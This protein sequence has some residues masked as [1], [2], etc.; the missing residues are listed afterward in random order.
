MA[1]RWKLVPTKRHKQCPNTMCGVYIGNGCRKCPKCGEIQPQTTKRKRSSSPVKPRKKKQEV[2]DGP[3]TKIYHSGNKVKVY[4]DKYKRWTWGVVTSR[5]DSTFA[6]TGYRYRVRLLGITGTPYLGQHGPTKWHLNR[7]ETS[8]LKPRMSSNSLAEP[9]QVKRKDIV[10]ADI[11]DLIQDNHDGLL[12]SY[13]QYPNCD[14]A[15]CMLKFHNDNDT[16]KFMYA[17]PPKIKTIAK[18]F[19]HLKVGSI[20]VTNAVNNWGTICEVKELKLCKNPDYSYVVLENADPDG[21]NSRYRMTVKHKYYTC[22]WF[23]QDGQPRRYYNDDNAFIEQSVNEVKEMANGVAIGTPVTKTFKHDMNN[24]TYNIV[25]KCKTWK[26]PDGHTIYNFVDSYQENTETKVKREMVVEPILKPKPRELS[27]YKQAIE[28][29]VGTQHDWTWLDSAEAKQEF[30]STKHPSNLKLIGC[31]KFN[32]PWNDL[33]SR[34]QFYDSFK[35]DY[36][37][38]VCYHGTFMKNLF[39][40]LH[41]MGGFAMASESNGKCYGQGVYFANSPYW[42]NDNGYAPA[43]FDRIRCIIVAQ[44]LCGKTLARGTDSWHRHAF[45][46]GRTSDLNRSDSPSGSTYKEGKFELTGGN[47]GRSIHVVWYDRCKTDINITHVLWYR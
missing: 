37:Q 21:N 31:T 30:S 8:H 20:L 7:I 33:T 22:K 43:G 27:T 10:Y 39:P 23:F 5:Y 6:R 42:V 41:P 15:P 11:K 34:K 28:K 29:V 19:K 1:Q 44:V 40:I 25:L 26:N 18:C 35:V 9:N 3:P 32:K 13:A 38:R 14:C 47:S 45:V 24:F 46:A 36:E 4:W 17:Q 2:A 12:F 16:N